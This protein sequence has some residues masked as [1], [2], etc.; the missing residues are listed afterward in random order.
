MTSS[1]ELGLLGT[2]GDPDMAGIF[3]FEARI[4]AYCR[5]EAALAWSQADLGVIPVSAAE[6]I[7]A[8]V[9]DLALDADRLRTGACLVGYPILP[10]LEQLRESGG[11]EVSAFAHW[12]ATT[13]DIM[14]S[15]LALQMDRG[16]AR[17]E[18]LLT[19]LGDRLAR[20]A[21]DERSTLIAG[22]THAQPAVPTSFGA[23]IAVWVAECARHLR[24]LRMARSTACV[25]S[26]F[27]AVGTGAALGPH[28]RETRHAVA[29]RLGLSAVDVPW[30]VARDGLV[31]VGSVLTS[32]A[33]TGGKIGR[34][35]IELSRPEIGE[36]AEASGHH[37]GASSTMPQKAN[38]I[39]SE[40]LVAFQILSATQLPGLLAATQTLHERAAGEWQ[41]EWDVLPLLFGYVAGSLATGSRLIDGLRVDRTRMAANVRSGGDTIMAEA[42]M[43]ALAPLVGR[44]RAHDL[45]YAACRRVSPDQ[46]TLE[47]ALYAELDPDLLARLPAL[48]EVL[49]PER[50][51]GEAQAIVDAAVSTWESVRSGPR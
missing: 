29:A 23:K 26:L 34:E 42:A 21:H 45:V 40:L 39:S 43:M 49:D 41:V 32:L 31:E 12:G 16:L 48:T 10:L 17:V 11:P 50:Y 33:A 27:G 3:S 15:G 14:D 1:P 51:L 20:L 28:G 44:E 9:R 36:L 7:D 24:R 25:V 5:V 47:A 4:E 30:H 2:F 13:Q 19:E 46:P 38:P 18:N 37:R 6:A 8:A 35:V 22:R